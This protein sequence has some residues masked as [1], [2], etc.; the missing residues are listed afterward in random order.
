MGTEMVIVGAFMDIVFCDLM[1]GRGLMEM[2]STVSAA[3]LGTCDHRPDVFR[4]R[5]S[6]SSPF[7]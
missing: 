7:H 3:V 5:R 2:R 6:S 1:Y 4:R